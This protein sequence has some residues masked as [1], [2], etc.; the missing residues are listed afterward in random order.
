MSVLKR[1]RSQSKMEYVANGYS[2]EKHSIDF[3]KRLSVKN[4]RIYQDAIVRLAVLQA[5]MAYIA[6]EIYPTNTAEYQVRRILLGVSMAVLHAL[7][8]RMADVY[9]MLMLNPQEAF[10]RQNG[11]PIP[12][13]EAIRILEQLAENL[14]TMIDTQDALLKGVR[15]S[16]K[17]RASALPPADPALPA[18]LPNAIKALS[19]SLMGLFL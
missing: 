7:D 4:A 10:S 5:D 3:V 9:E 11:K 8:K 19:D 18:V 17:A 12:N 1:K 13:A 16:D 2:I 15:D 14:G 6:N